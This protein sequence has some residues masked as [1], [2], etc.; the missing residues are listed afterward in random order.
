[1]P[2]IFNQQGEDMDFAVFEDINCDAEFDPSQFEALFE[3]I[4]GQNKMVQ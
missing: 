2:K 3:K 1:M 4:E